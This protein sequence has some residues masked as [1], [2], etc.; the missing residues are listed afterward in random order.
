MNK[1]DTVLIG[2]FAVCVMYDLQL[3]KKTVVKSS[4][5]VSYG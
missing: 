4:S 5:Y 2:Y 1:I 3:R